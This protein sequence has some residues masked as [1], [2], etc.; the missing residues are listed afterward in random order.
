MYWPA[1]YNICV[2]NHSSTYTYMYI[3]H[4]L[5]TYWSIK[6]GVLSYKRQFE[7]IVV[8]F[9]RRSLRRDQFCINHV[10]LYIECFK[11]DCLE[12]EFPCVYFIET[13]SCIK[14]DAL[15]MAAVA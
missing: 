12:N 7:S 5:H 8:R 6:S 14:C 2:D 3:V 13:P 15:S 10:L 1:I 4:L 9:T 11:I